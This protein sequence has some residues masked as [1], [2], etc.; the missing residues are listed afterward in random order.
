MNPANP[1]DN[2]AFEPGNYARPNQNWTCGRA[3]EGQ[4][5]RAGPDAK[6]RCGAKAECRPRLEIKPGQTKGRW[7]C[8][9]PE[10]CESGPLPD[11]RCSRP[12]ARCSPVPTLR[13]W[14][15]RA[16]LA[17]VA[18]A[19]AALLICLGVPPWR[20]RFISPGQLSQPHSSA[21]FAALASTNHLGGGCAAC[22]VAGNSGP[23]GL[24]AR[25]ARA[26]PGMGDFHGLLT[27]SAAAPTRMDAACLECH[28]GKNFHHP[29][30]PAISCVFCHKEHH[31]A[32]MAAAT[33][34]QCD[35]CHGNAATMSAVSA[36]PRIHHFATDHPE[37]RFIAEK[38]RD[39]DTLQ[40]NHQ[41][42]LTSDSIPKL[43]G[44]RKLDC[45]FCHQPDA[46]GAFMR[47]VNFERN[48]RVCHSLQFDPQTPELA[49]PHGSVRFVT[50]FLH[51]LPAQYARLAKREGAADSDAFVQHKLAALRSQFGSGAELERRVFFSTATVGPEEQ[52]G[53]LSGATR[54]VFPGCAYCHEVKAGP[55]GPEVTK[56][57]MRERWLPDAK[58][59]HASHAGIACARCHD[60]VESRDTADIILPPRETCLECHSPRGGVAHSCVE[61]HNYHNPAPTVA[62][63]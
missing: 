43:P 44:G 3:T 37:F 1:G 19:C 24:M 27:A 25:A 10:A 22:H 12:V 34:A 8:T 62:A 15:A 38:W 17:A 18:A 13:L 47:P 35:F 11:G 30:A 50:A 46:S 63:R 21:A 53:T 42:H 20:G 6:G 31:G 57:L 56:P 40:F 9:R 49:L 39:P 41:L 60:A 32:A 45:A 14:R 29:A 28:A 2:P 51:S 55:E 48:C 7:H 23:R 61:C 58:F 59:S 16:S 54:A 52:I 36:M 4:P 5:C 33:D 26:R